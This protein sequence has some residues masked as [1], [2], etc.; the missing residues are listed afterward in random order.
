LNRLSK[1]DCFLIFQL[2]SIALQEGQ[3]ELPEVLQPPDSN[4]FSE[5]CFVFMVKET[6]ITQHLT[7]EK[8]KFT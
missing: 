5:V 3:F 6:T 4:Y 1:Y 8:K 7:N 2:D